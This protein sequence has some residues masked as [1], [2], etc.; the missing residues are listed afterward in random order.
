MPPATVPLLLDAPLLAQGKTLDSVARK[1]IVS[2]VYELEDM[3]KMSMSL[4]EAKREAI[5]EREEMER[6]RKYKRECIRAKEEKRELPPTYR[7]CDKLKYFFD[8]RNFSSIVPKMDFVRQCFDEI[9]AD[10][11]R[12]GEDLPWPECIPNGIRSAIPLRDYI[13]AWVAEEDAAK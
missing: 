6:F 13:N 2:S 7:S 5:K 12:S 1:K 3:R 4:L 11:K 9:R 8:P 10:F